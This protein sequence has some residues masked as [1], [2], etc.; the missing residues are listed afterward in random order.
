MD[1][2]YSSFRTDWGNNSCGVDN[3]HIQR[4]Y[5][6]YDND[7]PRYRD[8]FLQRSKQDGSSHGYAIGFD[9]TDARKRE[10]LRERTLSNRLSRHEV[11]RRLR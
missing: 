3:R 9:F 11:L 6:L 1:Y 4:E 8:S 2:W 5:E 7:A 10:T